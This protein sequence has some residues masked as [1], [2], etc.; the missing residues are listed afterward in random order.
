MK[1]MDIH[2]FRFPRSPWPVS[3][4]LKGIVEEQATP[5]SW[6]WTGL[7]NTKKLSLIYMSIYLGQI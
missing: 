3:C 5:F 1:N 6:L 4:Q 7:L 2:V